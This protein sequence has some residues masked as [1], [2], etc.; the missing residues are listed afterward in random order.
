[1]TVR[2]SVPKRARAR[3]LERPFG[4]LGPAAA[5][6]LIA[7]DLAIVA[8][9]DGRQVRPT[10]SPAVDMRQIAHHSSLWAA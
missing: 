9:D 4:L 8:V 1:M 10:V 3:L 7:H 6:E 2:R 5:G